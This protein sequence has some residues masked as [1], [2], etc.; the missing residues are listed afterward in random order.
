MAVTGFSNR[1][2]LER[3]V[4]GKRWEATPL[5]IEEKVRNGEEGKTASACTSK[6]L[7]VNGR[8]A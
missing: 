1:E 3:V 2:A 4:S 5:W 6:R 7:A 8:S